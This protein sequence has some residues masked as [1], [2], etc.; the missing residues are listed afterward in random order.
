MCADYYLIP[1]AIADRYPWA[2]RQLNR[3]DM[4]RPD[5]PG[6]GRNPKPEEVR[7]VLDH[8]AGY[9][10]DYFVSEDNWQAD[11]RSRKGIPLFRKNSL[12]NVIDF[13]GDESYPHLVCFES[14]D[15]SLNLLI[16]E[17]LSRISGPLYMVADTGAQP[18]IVTPGSDPAALKQHWDI[19]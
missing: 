7:K 3:Y 4:E 6:A 1:T 5:T 13:N 9:S 15:I 14:G 2:M 8:L 17:R 11:I 10:V 16:A 18:L 12:L 19:R